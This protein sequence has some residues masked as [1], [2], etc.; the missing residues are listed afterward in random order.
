M[1]SHELMLK[2]YDR[3]LPAEIYCDASKRGIGFV[4]QQ[5][6]PKSGTKRIISCGSRTLTKSEVNWAIIELEC[7]AIVFAL[8]KLTG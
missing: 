7:L 8:Q 3:N 5:I 6:C 2:F 4:F 1:V